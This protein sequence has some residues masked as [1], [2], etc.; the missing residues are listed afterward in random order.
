VPPEIVQAAIESDDDLYA[1]F[2]IVFTRFSEDLYATFSIVFTRFSEDLYAIF[3]VFKTLNPLINPKPL[4]G[5]P[6]STQNRR[7]KKT[8][9]T[10]KKTGVG[11]SL[12]WDLGFLLANNSVSPKKQAE[13]HKKGA[14]GETFAAWLLYAKSAAGAGL[15]DKTGVSNAIARTL[16]SP[17]GGPG[18]AAG[19]LAS[20][21]PHHLKAMLENDLEGEEIDDPDYE[22]AF[23]TLP[24]SGKRAL[25][26]QLFGD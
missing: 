5:S 11:S 2:S 6:P 17:R 21:S 19:A 12:Y 1:D 8:N 10:R 9:V 26:K 14:S 4:E 22:A 15:Q 18:G 24:D 20:L 23:E 25:L 16:Q 13:L 3:R 7:K